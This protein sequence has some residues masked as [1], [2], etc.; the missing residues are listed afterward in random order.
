MGKCSNSL[1]VTLKALAWLAII[2]FLVL[3]SAYIYVTKFRN[4]SPLNMTEIEY[5]LTCFACEAR[6]NFLDNLAFN[7]SSKSSNDLPEDMDCLRNPTYTH[8]CK[9][10]KHLLNNTNLKLRL[11]F[12][13][14]YSIA[15]R[16][17]LRSTSSEA[18][19]NRTN[20][21]NMPQR[22]RKTRM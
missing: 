18:K 4:T 21:T 1:I 10:G 15:F 3:S 11:K 20:S 16:R 22:R 2:L 13:N 17:I 9:T 8:P 6:I 14:K 12:K 5:K 7:Q 19:R